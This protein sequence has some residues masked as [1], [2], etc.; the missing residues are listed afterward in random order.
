[1]K[2]RFEFNLCSSVFYL[3]L[4]L[5]SLSAAAA[6][7]IVFLGDSITDGDTYPQLVRQALAEAGKDVPICINA[8]I[9]GDTAAGMLKR[10]D[11]DVFSRKPTLMTLSAGINDSRGPV[12]E[13][14]FERDITA[15]ADRVT[16]A[17]VKLVILTT[18][19]L[20][21]GR[22]DRA[23]LSEK[24]DVI[25]RRVAA[26]HQAPVAEVKRLMTAAH[27]KRVELLQEDQV[28]PILAGQ[29]LI[30]RAVLD[31][32]GHA[33]VP[34][35]D[36]Q[37]LKLLAGVITQWRIRPLAD[38]EKLDA[39]AVAALTVDD[40]WKPL[41]LPQE[42]EQAHWWYDADRQR[43]FALSLEHFIA[44]AKRFVAVATVESEKPRHVFLNTGAHLSAV[45]LNGKP[46]YRSTQST[47]W[48]AGKERIA[49]DL[50]AGKTT[51]VIETGNAFFLSLTDD[52][53]W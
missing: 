48:H 3:W 8:G 26:A 9:G 15:I 12:S 5:F 39:K 23:A 25:L 35:P 11:R 2:R 38:Q 27:A 34:V 13:A 32:L 6:E 40:S 33:D 10:L 49:V 4:I 28:H 45:W 31:A 52:D 7:R 53:A 16:R 46:V 14:N 17:N 37:N 22:E 20:G 30:A 24:Y 50:P 21:R 1:M 42:Q 18:T 43:G 44:P 51:V 47:G 41:V 19:Y 29:A 36:K